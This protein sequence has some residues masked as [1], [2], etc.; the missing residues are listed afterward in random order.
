M[1]I[2]L[3]TILIFVL[4][5]FIDKICLW[6]ERKDWLYWRHKKPDFGG[7]V[8][9]ALQQLHVFLNPSARYTIQAKQNK[10][11]SHKKSEADSFNDL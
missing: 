5:Y 4:L 10:A 1:Q 9:N 7:G 6:L 2:L 3:A 8:G 11:G